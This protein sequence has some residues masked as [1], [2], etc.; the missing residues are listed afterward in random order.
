MGE[1][2]KLA[3]ATQVVRVRVPLAI[4][5]KMKKVVKET[6]DAVTI[7]DVGC[8][9]LGRFLAEV[10]LS[11]SETREVVKTKKARTA[12]AEEK[13]EADAKPCNC[14]KCECKG[15]G[16]AKKPAAAARK[17]KAAPKKRK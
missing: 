1:S 5:K 4:Y 12:K 15:K 10:V 13:A 17:P 11:R 6:G 3:A 2:K 7:S 8:E 16:K 9:A 14:G